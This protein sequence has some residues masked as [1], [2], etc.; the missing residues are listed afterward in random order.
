MSRAEEPKLGFAVEGTC[1][2]LELCADVVLEI[3]SAGR[4]TE[5]GI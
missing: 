2:L 5:G 1:L 3:G 4:P